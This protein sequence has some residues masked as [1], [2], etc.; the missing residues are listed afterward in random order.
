M[1]KAN[2]NG[3]LKLYP[4]SQQSIGL[5]PEMKPYHNFIFGIGGKIYVLIYPNNNICTP[6]SQILHNYLNLILLHPHHHQHRPKELPSYWPSDNRTFRQHHCPVRF[7]NPTP[8]TSPTNSSLSPPLSPTSSLNDYPTKL[9]IETSEHIIDYWWSGEYVNGKALYYGFNTDGDPRKIYWEI[10][11]DNE[12]WVV[13]DDH[14]PESKISWCDKEILHY[15]NSYDV[16]KQEMGI[17]V[18][19]CV[20]A[21]KSSGDYIVYNETYNG[22]VVFQRQ[23]N[24]DRYI[25]YHLGNITQNIEAGWKL[26]DTPPITQS[27]HLSFYAECNN[28]Q[29]NIFQCKSQIEF[30]TCSN[31]TINKLPNDTIGDNYI[32]T[33]IS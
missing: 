20:I 5:F 24:N 10:E 9:R 32:C 12:R 11:N 15:C 1:L 2:N 18:K 19:Y 22:R 29:G 28:N 25:Y 16:N 23:P 26:S 27:N 3:K 33:K 17:T 4:E 7:T 13:S 30:G 8:S 31:L 14:N 21:N 6:V